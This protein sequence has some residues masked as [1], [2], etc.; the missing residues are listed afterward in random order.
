M[1]KILV[2]KE[3]RR[4]TNYAGLRKDARGLQSRASE[5]TAANDTATEIGY[6]KRNTDELEGHMA[7]EATAIG[8]RSQLIRTVS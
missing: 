7:A 2:F 5:G 3:E 4:Q 1:V 8:R 6:G